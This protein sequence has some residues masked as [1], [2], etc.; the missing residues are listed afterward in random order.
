MSEQ[1]RCAS[2]RWW[3]QDTG[4]T[5]SPRWGDCV[6]LTSWYQPHRRDHRAPEIPRALGMA[7]G[8]DEPGFFRSHPDF[9]CIQWEPQS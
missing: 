5:Q 8:K 4:G 9:G 3:E 1:G 6:F 2:C 7:I